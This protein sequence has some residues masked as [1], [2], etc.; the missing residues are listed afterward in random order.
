MNA[1]CSQGSSLLSADISGSDV[2]DSGLFNI[3]DCKN[4]EALN[5]NF[6]DK[7]SDVGLGCISG[8]FML[9]D[10]LHYIVFSLTNVD[11]D[12]RFEVILV[13]EP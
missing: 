5:L 2:T 4:I 3:K 13:L 6:V 1:I 10:F 7:I 8:T 9:Q 12:M 11:L